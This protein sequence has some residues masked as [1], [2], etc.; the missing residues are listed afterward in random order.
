VYVFLELLEEE[1]GF[2]SGSVWAR[3][4]FL[5]VV[6]RLLPLGALPPASSWP[7]PEL[8]LLE[9]LLDGLLS[10]GHLSDVFILSL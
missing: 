8:L 4:G 5:V 9:F 3:L 10:S 1:S 7:L 2:L 6:L